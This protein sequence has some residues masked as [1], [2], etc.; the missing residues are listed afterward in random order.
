MSSVI[1]KRLPWTELFRP[2]TLDEV[3]LTRRQKQQILSW[4]RSWI[5]HWNLSR[6]WNSEERDKWQ[7][8]ARSDSG[9]S[10]ISKYLGKWKEFFREKFETWAGVKAKDIP[11]SH[12]LLFEPM[13]K[14]KELSTD[15]K[16]TAMR[17]MRKWI[18]KIWGEFL[19]KIRA[20]EIPPAIPPI[21]P[22]KPL[23]LVGP[24]GT[25]KTSSIYALAGQ[26]GII[27]VEFNASD[28]R[29]SRVIREIVLEA[30]K[31]AGFALGGDPNK[32]PRIVLLDEVDG[33]S[34]KE[35]RGGFSALVNVLDEIKLPLALTANVMHDR[36]VRFLMTR[37]VT[38]FFNRPYDYQ[39][40]T[41]IM[42]IAKRIGTQFP[43]NIIN[44]LAKYAPD[45]RT[46]VEALETYYYSG[47]LP[48]IFHEEMMSIQDAIR[49]AF[50]FKGDTLEQSAMKV[51][52]YLGSVTDLDV[53]DILLWVWENAYQ[54][55]DKTKGISAFYDALAYA[56]YLYKIGARSQN[57]RLA[58]RDAMNI[59]AYAIAKYGKPSK[60][61]WELR[62]LKVNKPTIIEELGRMKKLMEGEIE[63]AKEEEEEEISEEISP[64]KLGLRPLLGSY[65]RYTHTSRREA[66]REL[67]FLVFLVK[68]A[69]E[70]I[71]KLFAK[72]YIPKE[73]IQIFLRHFFKKKEERESIREKLFKA[74]EETLEKIGPRTTT[75]ATPLAPTP[76]QG[77]E[78]KEKKKEGEK[79][80]EKKKEEKEVIEKKPTLDMFFGKNE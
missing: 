25:G 12:Y 63:E 27:V 17:E 36:K 28:R 34:G 68:H 60:N 3:I 47:I 18:D 32:P 67:R 33:L 52:R 77:V 14:R 41:L 51:T 79:K 69:P 31:T 15:L 57:W 19:S 49:Y 16:P 23:L 9:K 73:T 50:A 39:I 43:E 64:K 53:W 70:E 71:G 72:L 80:E 56:D 13:D 48:D 20:E 26:E 37:S 5:I 4:W 62:K 35:D 24:P 8:F 29:N 7:K 10:W 38:V 59:L 65:A 22:Y 58:Y 75:F 1:S 46:V 61:I 78:T 21:A 66:R 76:L 6:L 42:R 74:Y 40:K 45:F 55:L 54:F 30:M 11:Q 44:Y 2:R